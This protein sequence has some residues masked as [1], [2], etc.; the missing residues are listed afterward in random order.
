MTRDHSEPQPP[1]YLPWARKRG[2]LG[3]LGL[4]RQGPQ[5]AEGT[6]RS[7]SLALQSHFP[8]QGSSSSELRALGAPPAEAACPR[9]LT[10]CSAAGALFVI[11]T[12]HGMAS[13]RAA[14]RVH[15]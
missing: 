5:R 7:P 9:A 2:T 12:T 8:Q 11:M 13:F 4:Q 3:P 14:L 6:K 10:P 1:C 15:V